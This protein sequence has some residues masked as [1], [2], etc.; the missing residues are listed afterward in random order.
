MD[1][2]KIKKTIDLF[3]EHSAQTEK[4]IINLYGGEPFYD[5]ELMKKTVDYIN[6][7]DPKVDICI[8]TNGLLLNKEVMKWFFENSNISLMVSLAGTPKIH[9]QLRVTV[10]NAPT[11][12]AIKENL[13]FAKEYDES[14]Y[15]KRINFIFNIFDE[16]QL[17][18]IQNFWDMDEIFQGI[19]YLPEVS[20]IDMDDKDGYMKELYHQIMK[21]FKKDNDPL[22]LY[23]QYLKQKDYNKIIVKFYDKRFL[24]LHTRSYNNEKAYCGGVCRPMLNR[25]FV[26]ADGNIGL[27]ENMRFAGELGDI[28]NGINI[29]NVKRILNG[30][31]A[32]RRV[33]C[34]NCWAVNLCQSCFK[35]VYS[36]SLEEIDKQKSDYNCG[37]EKDIKKR[38]L[39]E[40]CR[41]LEED[42]ALLDHLYHYVTEE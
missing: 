27:C 24:G 16:I 29:G 8:T 12:K 9:D 19:E 32:L 15:R 2:Q 22:E 13:L 3:F 42:E 26:D 36:G 38:Y 7:I 14:S 1:F 28:N 6:K 37:N 4:R 11:F 34:L 10:G 17:K 31:K 18:K 21:E 25:F 39:E 35:D 30:Y 23:I 20:F 5:F 40:Y 41:I 33:K